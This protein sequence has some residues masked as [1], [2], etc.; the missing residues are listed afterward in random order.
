MYLDLMIGVVVS[1]VAVAA[2]WVFGGAA[3]QNGWLEARIGKARSSAGVLPRHVTVEQVLPLHLGLGRG[4]RVT[5]ALSD[6]RVKALH[7][8]TSVD[9]RSKYAGRSKLAAFSDRSV[10]E[11]LYLLPSMPL[12][13]L[14]FAD[15]NKVSFTICNQAVVLEFPGRRDQAVVVASAVEVDRLEA[16]IDQWLTMAPAVIEG[17]PTVGGERP[18]VSPIKRARAL[19]FLVARLPDDATLK[20]CVQRCLR[21]P[22]PEVRVAAAQLNSTHVAVEVLRA[23]VTEGWS[24]AECAVV[25][26]NPDV[27]LLGDPMLNAIGLSDT[28][29]PGVPG[30]VQNMVRQGLPVR[31]R[32]LREQACIGLAIDALEARS[33]PRQL[34]DQLLAGTMGTPDRKNERLDAEW[35]LRE[36]R[37]RALKRLWSARGKARALDQEYLDR[38]KPVAEGLLAEED[39]EEALTRD[40][41]RLVESMAPPRAV[42]LALDL[43]SRDLCLEVAAST[44]GRIGGDPAV[45][46]LTAVLETRALT[47]GEQLAVQHALEEIR[48]RLRGR[49]VASRLGLLGAFFVQRAKLLSYQG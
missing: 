39:L 9:P 45:A 8:L 2:I 32:Q 1:G 13:G 6:P 38:L 37:R 46:P 47:D 28:P 14:I 44:L 27:E 11:P 31:A 21:S 20:A 5:V 35:A 33:T 40:A 10:V 30:E 29:L 3:E 43:L 7:G 22:D 25:E 48:G 49:P 16:V 36:R 42:E 17:I 18:W 34:A 4:F 26:A 23:M 24:Q 41:L 12:D 15:A 19:G